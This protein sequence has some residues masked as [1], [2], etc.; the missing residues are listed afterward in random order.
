MLPF[1]LVGDSF[2]SATGPC[3][4][5]K[6]PWIPFSSFSPRVARGKLSGW[7]DKLKR[8]AELAGNDESQTGSPGVLGPSGEVTKETKKN[9][10]RDRVRLQLRRTEVPTDLETVCMRQNR[11]LKTR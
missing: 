11:W 10:H 5:E 8:N 1:V 2:L 4:I 7:G 6:P 9:Q 3:F